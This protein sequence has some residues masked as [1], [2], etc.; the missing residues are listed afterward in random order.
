MCIALEYSSVVQKPFDFRVSTV[1][2]LFMKRTIFLK[3]T[4]PYFF[5][6]FLECSCDICHPSAVY[7]SILWVYGIREVLYRE[8]E[9]FFTQL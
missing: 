9:T 4:T 2:V 1:T 6:F 7:F 3:L 8:E 5:F